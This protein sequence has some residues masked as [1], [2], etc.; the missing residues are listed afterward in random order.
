FAGQI[1]KWWNASANLQLFWQELDGRNINPE[2]YNSIFNVIAQVQSRFTL[3]WGIELQGTYDI[4]SR[5]AE[6]IANE[7][8]RQRLDLAISK[9]L[10]GDKASL[11]FSVTDI[12]DTYMHV[13]HTRNSALDQTL[14]FK[15]QTRYAMLTYRYNFG[16]P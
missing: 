8:G 13:E 9:K 6:I 16:Q 14:R 10:Q 15:W 4:R 7:N 5:E 12:F 1:T 11:T 3:P 2:F